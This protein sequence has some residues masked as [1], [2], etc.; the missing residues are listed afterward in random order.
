METMGKILM[1]VLAIASFAFIPSL[2]MLNQ[3]AKAIVDNT[4]CDN[5]K[6][7]GWVDG[8]KNGW[9]DHDHC[10]AYNPVSGDYAKG[11]VVGWKKGHCV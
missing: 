8:C 9:Y 10:R 2:M 4:F 3:P 1:I 6:S 7:E 5:G 11:Y